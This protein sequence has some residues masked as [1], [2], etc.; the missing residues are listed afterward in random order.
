[1]LQFFS[2]ALFERYPHIYT[3]LLCRPFWAIGLHL[4]L[5]SCPKAIKGAAVGLQLQRFS[6]AKAINH[7]EKYDGFNDLILW[8]RDCTS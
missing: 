2:Y 3:T 7:K 1:M 5:I 8:L 6:C 4:R